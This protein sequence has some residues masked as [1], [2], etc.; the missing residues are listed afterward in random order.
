ME[1]ITIRVDTETLETIDEEAAERDA[2]RSKVAR[3]YIRMGTEYEDLKTEL[4]RKEARIK[5]LRNQLKARG[6]MEETMSEI[7]EYTE[8][9]SEA[10]RELLEERKKEREREREKEQE[11]EAR[12]L[13]V[14]GR[15]RRWLFGAPRSAGTVDARGGG[16]RP[17]RAEAPDEDTR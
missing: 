4:D 14:V 7:V 13:G 10:L 5:E 12:H 16:V 9:Q 6:S 3:D 1:Q 8:T 17:D 2:S 11:V 15:T